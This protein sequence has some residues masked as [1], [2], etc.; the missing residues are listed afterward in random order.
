MEKDSRICIYN[1]ENQGVSA[2]RNLG[3]EKASGKYLQ[4]VDADDYIDKFMTEKMAS[5]MK[6]AELVSCGCIE[7]KNG[8]QASMAIYASEKM[9]QIETLRAMVEPDSIRGFLPNKLFCTD[10]IKKNQ[11]RM[12]SE[13]HVCEDLVFCLEY[14]AYIQTSA[15]IPQGLY[16]YVYREDSATHKRFNEKRFSVIQAFEEIRKLTLPYH[17]LLLNKKV[18]AHYL[19]LMIQLFVMLKRNHYSI[20]S[21]EMKRIMGN[22]KKRKLCLAGTNW[23]LKYKITCVPI[24]ILSF[25]YR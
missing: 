2:A 17:D 7:D 1:Q 10:I 9:N 4:F 23:D 21:T 19:V 22:M 5:A 6:H 14:A 18:E 13:I 16:Y 8:S 24:K 15:F 12:R 20:F 3:I 25:M 11:I